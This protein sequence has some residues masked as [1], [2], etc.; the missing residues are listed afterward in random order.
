[1]GE[2]KVRKRAHASILAACPFCIYCGGTTHATTIDHVPPRIMFRNKYRPKGLEFPSCNNCNAGTRRSDLV[3]AMIGRF[4]PNA[5][6]PDEM[7][8]ILQA[9]SNNI[10]GLLDEMYLGPAERAAAPRT[11]PSHVEGQLLRANGPL[12]RS[13][14]QT[15]AFKMGFALYYEI[16][17]QI[18]PI[19]GGVVARWFSNVERWRGECPDINFPMPP[20]TL[21]QGRFEVSDQ[22]A[23]QGGATNDGKM[24]F[25][26]SY[27]RASFAVWT[28][29]AADKSVFEV[30]TRYPMRICEP[31]RLTVLLTR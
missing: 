29:V 16:T 1:M 11:L 7:K 31:G 6:S 27:F 26:V 22:F 20:T 17:K 28:F 9:V 4:F 10:P 23:Y 19:G 3:A 24:V 14:M 18:V 25:A 21:K 12:V 2:S 30:P 8:G 15:F 5:S 13:H